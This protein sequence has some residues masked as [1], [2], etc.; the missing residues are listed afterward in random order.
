MERIIETDCFYHIFNRGTNKQEIFHDEKDYYRF[1]HYLYVCNDTASMEKVEV[2]T[3][4]GGPT[5]GN[6]HIRDRLVDV[7][8][9]ALMPN[10]FHLLLS[11]KKERGISK[12]MQKLCTGYTMYY[13]NKYKRTGVL[14]QGK[15]KSI[16]VLDEQYLP[17]LVRYIHLNPLELK[18]LKTK[19]EEEI[20]TYLQYYKW[21]SCPDYLGHKNFPSVLSTDSFAEIFENYAEHREFLMENIEDGSFEADKKLF[22]DLDE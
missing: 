7:V 12:F 5:S 4:I 9:F 21:S 17:I 1:I 19:S 11:Q 22:I 20:L 16:P 2:D 14:F 10:H 3:I 13:N 18:F 6:S 15:Y 8:C